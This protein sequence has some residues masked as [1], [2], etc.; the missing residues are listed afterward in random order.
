MH[1]SRLSVAVV[2]VLSSL[3]ASGQRAPAPRAAATAPVDYSKYQERWVTPPKV[4][5]AFLAHK[6]Y[7]SAAMD[8]EVGYHVYLPPGYEDVANT[9][10]RYPVV[11]WLH[12]L[13]QSESGNW[14]PPT[15]LDD[16]VRTGKVPPVI[17]VFVSGGGRT[18]Y[19]DSAD[20][21]H[22]SETTIV[23][24]LIPH[25]DATYRTVAAREGRAIQGMSMGGFGALRIAMTYPDVFSSV[26][27]YAPSLRQPEDL[28]ATY[29]DVLDRMFGGDPK[30]FWAQHPLALARERAERLRGRL[31]IAFYCGTKDHLLQ[32]SRDLHALLTEL[33]IEH[34]YEEVEGAN[35]AMP[36][37][38]AQIKHSNL[39]FAAKHF[40]AAAPAGAKPPAG[41]A[42]DRWSTP[43]AKANPL[44]AHRT[45]RS[46]AMNVE[47]GY[48][49]YVPPGYDDAENRDARYPVLYWLHG[50]GQD[51]SRDQYPIRLLD[52]AIRGKRVP[53]M[54]VVYAS[55]GQ[56]THYADS[57]D[58]KIL[59]ETAVIKELIPH[60]DATYRTRA[61]RGGRA[62]AG[63][64]M[65]GGGALKFAFKHPELFSSVS[66]FAPAL[67]TAEDFAANRGDVFRRMFDGR[68]ELYVAQHPETLVRGNAGRVR[69]RVG[70]AV[71]IGT[72][73]PL[74]P[75]S[76]SLRDVMAE[77]KVDCAYRE[78]DGVGHDLPK[79]A[80]KAG[81]TPFEFAAKHFA[82]EARAR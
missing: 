28:A 44:L 13:N 52:D 36:P 61:D 76:R 5:H 18:F 51:E 78:Y 46:A 41:D 54:V 32:G 17:V 63:M 65:G 73:D 19:V 35:H 16:A 74:L 55:G 69:G 45:F 15:I 22:L 72:D 7:R 33:R 81:V 58:G 4:A 82:S 43:P 64:S 31:P 30:R 59:A 21:K 62:V 39:A 10:R 1:V 20:G 37:L 23:K 25:V 9:G 38:A 60:V 67:R 79:L 42:P 50:R 77:L 56:R 24:E 49:L 11:Y 14:Y 8:T 29:P 12:G 48:N 75:F 40:R 47:V 66:A 80:E 27:A 34:V 53:P 57:V 3:V 71:H 68:A 70:V 6:T 2:L 26:A